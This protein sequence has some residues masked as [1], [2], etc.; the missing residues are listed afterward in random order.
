M[1]GTVYR[2]VYYFGTS[3][4]KREDAD[5]ITERLHIHLE[6]Y[7]RRK[8]SNREL[9][10]MKTKFLSESIKIA[11]S[12]HAGYFYFNAEINRP[13]QE[14]QVI[15]YDNF[16]CE[17]FR[18]AVYTGEYTKKWRYIVKCY[19]NNRF[20]ADHTTNTNKYTVLTLDLDNSFNSNRVQNV[21]TYVKRRGWSCKYRESASGRTHI[22]ILI[23]GAL[24]WSKYIKSRQMLY[25]DPDR[26]VLDILRYNAKLSTGVLWD[27]KAG[28]HAG[29]WKKCE[30]IRRR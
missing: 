19:N 23:P 6:K 26:V 16:H 17:G 1:I 21:I 25:D 27:I 10:D 22:K 2:T 18:F 9:R 3:F 14:W 20:S 4:Y 28:R 15:R 5:N 29:E 30:I 24:R 13:L 11:D 8:L 12:F 7:T